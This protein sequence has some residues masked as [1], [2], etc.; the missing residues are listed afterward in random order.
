M[1][2]RLVVDREQEETPPGYATDGT[3]LGGRVKFR[4][5]AKGYRVAIDPI[6]L[7]ASVP[8]EA[9]ERVLDL[10]SGAGAAAL[11]LATRVA[12]CRIDCLEAQDPLAR[13]AAENVSANKLDR[14]I[15]VHVGDLRRPPSDL[16]RNGFDHVMTNPPYVAS[17]AADA[18]P[19]PSKRKA[20][21]DELGVEV[22]IEAALKFLKPRGRLTLIHR[23]DRLDALIASLVPRTGEL[24][25]I[26][27][28]PRADEA[29]RRVIVRARKGAKSPA[30]LLPGLVLH[31]ADGSFTPEAEAVLRD[32]EA[33]EV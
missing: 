29:A 1:R 32:G 21:V 33:L 14:R 6:L 20:T 2:P 13:L 4:Q 30:Q 16:P 27:L 5:P 22:W 7:A 15:I 18:P 8:V 19:D 25:V 9:D 17:N 24:T 28:W 12:S 11:C 23:A 3:L 10:G 31:R 26:P